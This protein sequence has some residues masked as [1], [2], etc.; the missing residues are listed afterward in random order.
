MTDGVLQVSDNGSLFKEM[1]PQPDCAWCT[2][3]FADPLQ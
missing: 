3:G 2:Y 1:K